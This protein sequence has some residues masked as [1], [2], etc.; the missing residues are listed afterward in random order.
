M[1]AIV[2]NR[3]ELLFALLRTAICGDQL[4]GEEV[5][6]L[7]EESWPVLYGVAQKHDVA[8]LVGDALEKHDLLAAD[9]EYAVRFSKQIMMAVFRYERLNHDLTEVCHALET[10][11]IPFLP[12]KGSV[13]RQ[14]YPEPWM[15]TSCDIDILVPADKVESAA[16]YLVNACGYVREGAGRHDISMFSPNKNHVELHYD[17]VEEGMLDVSLDILHAVWENTTV[18]EGYTCWHEMT[19][20][21]FYFYHIVHMAKHFTQGGCGIRPFLDLWIIDHLK[22]ID[23]SKREEMI[24]AGGLRTFTDAARRL[25]RV[26]LEGAAAD[27]R[28]R[29]ME[30]FILRGG[31]YGSTENRV[32]VQQQREGGRF[33]YALSKIFIPY[34]VIKFHYPV[35]Q[36]HRWLTPV[37][38]VRRWGKL[39]FCGGAKRSVRELQFNSQISVVDAADTKRFLK[40]IGL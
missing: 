6:L 26:W 19:D 34:D 37:M 35:L 40:D 36:R 5:N 39:I 29:Q 38:E 8:P 27:A 28:A 32:M 11:G 3:V 33:K 12:L 25:T 22:G 7:T 4:S 13:L 30:E 17:L 15:R 1:I 9:N 2:H 14:Y 10:A 20:E 16:D 21:M 23:P 18:R 24:D 31:V